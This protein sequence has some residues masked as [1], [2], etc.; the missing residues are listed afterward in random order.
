VNAIY[1]YHFFWGLIYWLIACYELNSSSINVCIWPQCMFNRQYH[2]IFK[3][4]ISLFCVLHLFFLP[5]SQ[6]IRTQEKSLNARQSVLYF[7]TI[8][9]IFTA[10]SMH[11]RFDAR[12][13]VYYSPNASLRGEVK[14]IALNDI[15]NCQSYNSL[16]IKYTENWLT[17]DK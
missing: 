9:I 7:T 3:L 11:V 12:L 15:K 8:W 4:F 14:S 16:L 6:F 17:P 10:Y 2:F 1:F 5:L 13:L